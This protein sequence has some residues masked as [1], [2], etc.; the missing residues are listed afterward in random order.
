MIFKGAGT[1]LV[2]PFNINGE[3]DYNS[4]KKILQF[5]T[6]NKIDAVILL[7]TTGESPSEK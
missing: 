4:L 7:G 5:Q 6:E 3:V 1:A 2:T